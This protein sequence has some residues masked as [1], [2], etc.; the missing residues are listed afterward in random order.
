MGSSTASE[1][2]YYNFD[3]T[4][5]F[6][7]HWVTGAPCSESRGPHRAADLGEDRHRRHRG[8]GGARLDAEGRRGVWVNGRE[9]ALYGLPNRFRARREEG[10]TRMMMVA[11]AW[12]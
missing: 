9:R 11:D 1:L 7:M 3:D 10:A 6:A 8:G 5:K 2:N 4:G 12:G